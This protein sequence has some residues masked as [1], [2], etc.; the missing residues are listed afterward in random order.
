MIWEGCS[1]QDDMGGQDFTCCGLCRGRHCDLHRDYRWRVSGYYGGWVDRLFMRFIDIMLSIP[2]FFLILAVI[3]FI[4][5]SIWNIMTV[6][7]L[8]SW[9]GVARLVRAEFLS[10]KEREFVLA[11]KAIG[12]SDIRLS[13]D[14]F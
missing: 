2:T 12:A 8:T 5:P 13:S 3:A 1:E 4:G 10:L 6:I 7:G 11:A 14:I 9:M